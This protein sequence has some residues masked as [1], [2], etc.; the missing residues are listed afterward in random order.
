[1][2][3]LIEHQRG[4]AAK[5]LALCCIIACLAVS[6]RANGQSGVITTIAGDS[7]GGYSGDGG[8]ATSAQLDGPSGL[9]RDSAGNLYIADTGNNVIRKVLPCGITTSAEN[10][11]A[12]Y[13]GD[14]GPAMAGGV[15]NSASYSPS[16]LL[17]PGT[18][19]SIFGSN[20]ANG[21]SKAMGFP[22]PSQLSGTLVTIGGVAAPLLY[23]GNGQVNA[24]VPYGLPVNINAQIIVQQGNAY[25]LPQSIARA[26]A[27]PGIFTTTASGTGQGAMIRPDGNFAQP[28]TPAQAGDEIAIYAAGLGNTNP[29][30]AN[31]QAA[32]T[33]PLLNVVSP[34]SVTIGEHNAWVDFAGLAPGFTGLYQLNVAVPSGVSGNAVPV[35]LTV[36]GQPRPPVTMAVQ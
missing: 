28:G 27:D 25:T 3:N 9:A 8:P 23:A 34:V 19:V 2:T 35:V 17:S 36:G 13:S 12:G 16:A 4:T 18:M 32:T 7:N 15:V 31:G 11:S 26:A 29:E 5:P 1:M 33:S 14:G 21:T 10:G 24:L 30:A 20:L 6:S 22:L